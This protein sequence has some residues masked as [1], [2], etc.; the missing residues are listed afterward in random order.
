MPSTPALSMRTF[1]RYAEPLSVRAAPLQHCFICHHLVLR[2]IAELIVTPTRQLLLPFSTTGVRLFWV[3][4]WVPP[5]PL[6]VVLLELPLYD[7]PLC[8]AVVLLGQLLG[9]DPPGPPCWPGTGLP[10]GLPGGGGD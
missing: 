7:E 3:P 10:L 6:Y 4:V 5:E 9:A 2:S 8:I 1:F